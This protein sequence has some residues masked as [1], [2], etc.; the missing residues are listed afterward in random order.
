MRP[1]HGQPEMGRHENREDKILN[2]L[3]R[4]S[5]GGRNAPSRNV[6]CRIITARA[7]PLTHTAIAFR[8][9]KRPNLSHIGQVG[10]QHLS[11]LPRPHRSE[12]CN[13]R[14]IPF[15]GGDIMH[16]TW[17]LFWQQTSIRRSCG[18]LPKWSWHEP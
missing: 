7:K 18:H 13:S 14:T 8:S 12:I 5:K 6:F 2:V 11:I 1:Q 9:L 4:L 17:S 15:R 10:S 16:V 3:P